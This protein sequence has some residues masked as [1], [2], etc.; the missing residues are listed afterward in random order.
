MSES[1]MDRREFMRDAAVAAAGIA[2]LGATKRKEDAPAAPRSSILNYNENMQYRRAGRTNLM[3]S[4][5]CLGGH[6]KRL[7][8]M[9]GIKFEKSWLDMNL[10]KNEAFLKNRADVVSKCIEVGINYI[11]ACT[12]PEVVAYSAALKGRRDKMYLGYSWYEH[13]SRRQPYCESVEEMMKAFEEGLK[14]CG[15]DYVD[16][17]RITMQEQ[18]SKKNT[19]K[20]IEVAMTCLEKAK[21]DGKARFTG[22]SSHDR[23]WICEAIAK[24]PQLEVI[25]TPI[26]PGTKPLPKDS[27]FDAV[28]THDVAL[29]GIKPFGGTSLFKGDSSPDSPQREEDDRLARMALRYVMAIPTVTAPI[30]G[31][32]NAQQVENAAKAVQ[33]GPLTAAEK[34]ELDVAVER[35]WANLPADHLWLRNWEWA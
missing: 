26:T 23:P 29:F 20:Q 2:A 34:A 6:W 19:E 4:A 16:I 33:E 7:D 15:L 11:D 5:V 22:V 13:E 24:Y 25:C 9:P 8:K 21:K 12:G 3:I 35:M 18:T 14:I 10:T 1:R 30:P 28:K 27:I 31:L 32:M 17:W